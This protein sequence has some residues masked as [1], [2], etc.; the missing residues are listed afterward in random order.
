MNKI[1]LIFCLS[2]SF[3]VHTK[4]FDGLFGFKMGEVFDASKIT[5]PGGY[6]PPLLEYE[7]FFDKELKYDEYIS[8]EI[9]SFSKLPFGILVRVKPLIKNK[10][11][12]NYK[13]VLSPLSQRIIEIRAEGD[14]I[15][16]NERCEKI[17][18][19]IFL[20]LKKDYSTHFN[21]V[22]RLSIQEY[23]TEENLIHFLRLQE[24]EWVESNVYLENIIG[25]NFVITNQFKEDSQNY[26]FNLRDKNFEA[27]NY[28]LA[29]NCF[30]GKFDLILSSLELNQMYKD[31]GRIIKRW[32]ELIEYTYINKDVDTDGF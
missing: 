27:N 3:N 1:I 29:I 30:D 15:L 8:Q 18:S 2:I 6:K 4:E 11:F 12:E 5:T 31:E 13:L 25:K 26:I 24:K 16:N 20:N 14:V 7:N 28:I 10:Y 21:V 17:L 32:S 22:S 19:D 9:K 23:N